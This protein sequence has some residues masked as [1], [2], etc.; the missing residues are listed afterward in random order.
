MSSH[1]HRTHTTGVSPNAHYGV[2][3]TVEPSSATAE[4]LQQGMLL[5]KAGHVLGQGLYGKL[6]LSFAWAPKTV[7][8]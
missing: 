3:V 1:T 2:G 7:L 5:G 8:Y 6:L 4:P